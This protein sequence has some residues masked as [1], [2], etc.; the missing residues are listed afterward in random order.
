M[1]ALEVTSVRVKRGF[2]L[3]RIHVRLGQRILQATPRSGIAR[4][5]RLTA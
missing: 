4:K 3:S 2:S 5:I 1:R